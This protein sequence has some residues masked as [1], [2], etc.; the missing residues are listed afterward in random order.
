MKNIISKFINV[1]KPQ[2]K[3]NEAVETN[4]DFQVY[5]NTWKNYN[6]YGADLEAYGIK[7]GWMSIDDA[8]E[9]CE[10]HAEDEPFIN[11]VD[12]NTGLDI[13]ISE[14]DNAP[15]K[16]R[17]I[18]EQLEEYENCDN[19]EVV[20]AI[21]EAGSVTDLSEAIEIANSGDYI[22]FEGVSTD[23]ELAQAY[24]D[25][26]GGIV[27]AVGKDRLDSYF[28]EDAWKR[29]SED[30]FRNMIA[31][32][33]DKDVD[34]ITDEEIEDFADSVLQDEIATAKYDNNDSFFESYFDYD[35][36]GR[37]L[38]FDYTF[39]TDGAICIL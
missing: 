39:V 29:D 31:D 23:S 4:D 21:L 37:D 13:E 19:K 25:M 12:N 22:W 27:E 33:E 17:E 28:D 6:E 15:T 35:A 1:E 26:C 10:E 5:M 30:D 18:K 24:I 14:Y 38:G 36:F 34:D 7:D 20:K 16:L 8:I 11:D 2:K 9:F 32:S 3:L